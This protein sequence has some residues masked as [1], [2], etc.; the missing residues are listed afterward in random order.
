MTVTDVTSPTTNCLNYDGLCVSIL[1]S[2][3]PQSLSRR[4]NFIPFFA[5]YKYG[6]F[7]SKWQQFIVTS[8]LYLASVYFL[9]LV[10]IK[11]V[12]GDLI[13]FCRHH[14]DF[15]P[16]ESK[17]NRYGWISQMDG[18]DSWNVFLFLLKWQNSRGIIPLFFRIWHV[19]H[20]SFE[21]FIFKL[22]GTQMNVKQYKIKYIWYYRF[23]FCGYFNNDLLDQRGHNGTVDPINTM[24]S[25]SITTHIQTIVQCWLMTYTQM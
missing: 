22:F 20:K 7:H 2:L 11:L 9:E 1:W 3:L 18:S 15:I 24:C 13:S 8:L 5:R 16:P 23:C 25:L 10:T 14:W 12:V 17:S 21:N 4:P 6:H 19:T